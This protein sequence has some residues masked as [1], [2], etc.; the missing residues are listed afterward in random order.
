LGYIA[1]TIVTF[2]ALQPIYILMHEFTHSTAAWLL[3]YMPSPLSIVWGNFLTMKGWDEGVPY[4]RLFSSSQNPA[5]AII[6]GSPLLVHTIVVALGLVLLQRPWMKK[7][8]WLFHTLY[9]FVIVNFMELIGYIV[10]GSFAPG[11]DTGH[12]NHGLGL[13]PWFLFVAGT[14]VIT[15]G[16]YILFSK[17]V[18]LMDDVIAR[19]N[20]L[21]H[22]AILLMTA[23]ILFLWGSGL[24]AMSLYPD[25]QWMFGLLGVAAFGFV[26]LTCNPNRY[27]GHWR[28]S[29]GA[30]RGTSRT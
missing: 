26:L 2:V 4:H 1:V 18:P 3:G 17:I 30:V 15:I 19:R 16:L 8:K 5:E 23:F 20:H 21:T 13:S 9:W 10:M 22:W 11:G 24:E 12:F 25:P 29:S 14:L 28:A 6:G 7:N 27:A